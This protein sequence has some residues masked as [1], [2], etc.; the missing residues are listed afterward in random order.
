MTKIE[1]TIEQLIKI[2][3]NGK[4][5]RTGLGFICFYLDDKT[6]LELQ[7]GEYHSIKKCCECSDKN[8][9]IENVLNYIVNSKKINKE[10][11]IT[12]TPINVLELTQL[13][14]KIKH[15]KLPKG[16][17][18]VNGYCIGYLLP[19]VK[20]MVNLHDYVQQNKLSPNEI[21]HI[22]KNLYTAVQE[23]RTNKV[24]VQYF[25]AHNILF[26]PTTYQVQL[27]G[28]EDSY[29]ARVIEYPTANVIK[30]VNDSLNSV[31]NY[32]YNIDEDEVYFKELLGRIKKDERNF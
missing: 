9:Q 18:Y 16:F 30:N 5:T 28:L 14:S 4:I 26:N 25:S 20:D 6:Q 15:T 22:T 10:L 3:Q 24:Y 17:A 1:L 23:L 13:Q 27:I 12:S 31:R 19:I 21:G 11:N 7:V 29:C 8:K 2:I 32:L